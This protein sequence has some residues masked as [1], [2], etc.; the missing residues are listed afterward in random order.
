MRKEIQKFTTLKKV[1]NNCQRVVY[2]KSFCLSV[3]V[4]FTV[5]DIKK[6]LPKISSSCPKC[7]EEAKPKFSFYHEEKLN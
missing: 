3:P 6:Q 4:N 2:K 7:N 1:C 5:N